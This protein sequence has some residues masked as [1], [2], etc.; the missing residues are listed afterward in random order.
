M[1]KFIRETYNKMILNIKKTKNY[2]RLFKKI[3]LC[4]TFAYNYNVEYKNDILENAIDKISKH[5]ESI[6]SNQE[7]KKV[8]FFDSFG[9]EYR[10]LANQYIDAL[11]KKNIDFEYVT[12]VRNDIKSLANKLNENNIKI[13]YITEEESGILTLSKKLEEC[14]D[15]ILYIT[16]YDIVSLVCAR[17]FDGKKYLINLTDHAFWLGVNYIDYYIDFRNYGSNISYYY[18]NIP[19]NKILLNP[20]YPLFSDNEFQGYPCEKMNKNNTIFSGGS[21][22]KTIDETLLYYKIVNDVLENNPE[23]YFWYAGSG[24]MKYLLELQS[25]FPERVYI[26]KERN[27]LVEILRHSRIYLSTYPMIGGLMSQ[28]CVIANIPALT[29]LYDE[30]SSGVLLEQGEK[31]FEYWKFDDLIKEA[32]KLIKDEKYYQ[33]RIEGWKNNIISKE[34]FDENLYKII[35]TQKSNFKTVIDSEPYDT[36]KFLNTY[37]IRANKDKIK[38]D[39]LNKKLMFFKEFWPYYF[40]YG[41]KK[42]LNKFKRK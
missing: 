2:K 17:L 24:E 5:F 31:A 33:K 9:F 20:Y 21:I 1:Q 16:P 15:F 28:Y 7:S 23:T 34:D 37:I 18:R 10:G 27:D 41:F 40:K 38:I 35:S 13:T 42:L 12:Y 25:K 11:L 4:A 6:K 32:N 29:L 8:L 19:K 26:T 22:Y 3:I 36:S 39:L 14:S 30:C